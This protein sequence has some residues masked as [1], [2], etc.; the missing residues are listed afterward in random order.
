MPWAQTFEI[1]EDADLDY[2]EVGDQPVIGGVNE[3]NEQ[4]VTCWHK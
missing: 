4:Y 1:Q 3:Q 2:V